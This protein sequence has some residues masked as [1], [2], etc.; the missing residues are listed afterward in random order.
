MIHID[1]TTRSEIYNALGPQG[2]WHWH[3]FG[4]RDYPK[5]KMANTHQVDV[6]AEPHHN[7]VFESY[8]GDPTQWPPLVGIAHQFLR[9]GKEVLIICTGLI[10]DLPGAAD[11]A[12]WG[13]KFILKTDGY[14]SAGKV[15]L[16]TTFEDIDQA[17]STL[18]SSLTLVIEQYAHNQEDN[19]RKIIETTQTQ[20]VRKPAALYGGDIA[21]VV[22]YDGKWLY[23]V[24][25]PGLDPKLI[26]SMQGYEMLRYYVAEP[27]GMPISSCASLPKRFSQHSRPVDYHDLHMSFDHILHPNRQHWENWSAALCT[28]WHID[29]FDTSKSHE[30]ETAGIL[31]KYS[32][33]DFFQLSCWNG[34][35]TILRSQA[36]KKLIDPDYS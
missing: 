5:N 32:T 2:L 35:Q 27:N 15:Y 29:H 17:V 18:G 10:S 4:Q 6:Q 11:L 20:L 31:Y 25:S 22:D 28:D 1:P 33:V 12:R 13:A 23:D 8:Y 30:A 24:R 26:R 21:P 19:Y 16:G 9:D 3:R 14:D 7:V 36:W 34:Q